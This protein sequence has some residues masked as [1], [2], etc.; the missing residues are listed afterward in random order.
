[1]TFYSVTDD[2]DRHATT[3]RV[4]PDDV[5]LDI[6]DFCRMDKDYTIPCF[7]DRQSTC[8]A[9]KWKW[10]LLAHVCRRWRQIVFASPRRLNLRIPCT[11]RTPVTKNLGIWPAFPIDVE[12]EN[13][14][15]CSDE[16]NLNVVSALRYIDRVCHV[17]LS[18]PDS[19]V[20]WIATAMQKPFP[21]L[22]QLYL[23]SNYWPELVLPAGFLGGSAPCLQ[24]IHLSN[25]SYPALPT[26]LLSTRDLVKLSLDF[27]PQSGYISFEAIAASLAALPRL[28][29]FALEFLSS[30]ALTIIE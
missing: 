5:L 13:H 19:R 22:T 17:R 12:D 4:L 21:M 28:E 25:I 24:A 23:T 30:Y 1:M 7:M 16:V 3:I 20:R 2:S 9:W 18:F 29:R 6:F 15:N 14:L 8:D 10:H 26:L 27:I 11:A